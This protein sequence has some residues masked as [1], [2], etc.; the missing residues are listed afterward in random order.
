MASSASTMSEPRTRVLAWACEAMRLPTAAD[1]AATANSSVE[2]ASDNFS[3]A[4][5]FPARSIRTEFKF[6]ILCSF[7]AGDSRITRLVLHVRAP[8]AVIALRSSHM[9]GVLILLSL[10]ASVEAGTIQGVVLEQASGRPLART[11]VRLAAVP[12]P[13]GTAA[14]SLATR[15]GR[16][17]AFVFP[18]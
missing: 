3:F 9:H 4:R 16:S 2:I 12:K 15:S 7:D 8:P 1:Q 18:V 10:A 6:S 13:G 11:V 5:D 14:Q 17:G